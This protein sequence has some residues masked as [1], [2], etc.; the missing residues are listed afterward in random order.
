MD[1]I[2]GASSLEM[3]STQTSLA[4]LYD[5]V[6][7]YIESEHLARRA[8]EIRTK[9]LE[10]DDPALA[11]SFHNLAHI[12]HR[13]LDRPEEAETLYRRA[14]AIREK[15]LATDDPSLIQ[16]LREYADF[17]R[18]QSRS[19]EAEKLEARVPTSATGSVP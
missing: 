12:Y 11:E 16:T 1:I 4:S 6:G 15:Q 18:D 14:L 2:D 9:L 7:R 3:A 17:L 19:K 10:P 13:H 8:F 5:D